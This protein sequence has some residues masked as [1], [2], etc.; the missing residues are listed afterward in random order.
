MVQPMIERNVIAVMEAIE[1]MLPPLPPKN[2]SCRD[3]SAHKGHSWHKDGR[4][5]V[6]RGHSFDYT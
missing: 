6:C 5:Y 3:R 4:D 1:K 2:E